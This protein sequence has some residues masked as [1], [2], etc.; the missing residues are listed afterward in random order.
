MSGTFRTFLK[1]GSLFTEIQLVQ[2]FPFIVNPLII[3]KMLVI[4]YGDKT[5]FPLFDEVDFSEIAEIIVLLYGDKWTALINAEIHN[6]NIAGDGDKV[7]KTVTTENTDTIGSNN[8]DNKIASY[9]ED[10]LITE[11]GNSTATT[12]GITVAG[13]ETKTE[14]IVSFDNL[15]KNL[16]QVQKANILNVV[17]KDVQ[18]Y[19]TLD[20]Y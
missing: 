13:D 11:S 16:K 10:S 7:T 1:K 4:N 6:I 14:S 8:T 19:L 15:F 5:L 9:N 20:I 3:D 18:N 17:L 12:E 2:D